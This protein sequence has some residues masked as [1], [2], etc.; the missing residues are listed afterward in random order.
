M[1]ATECS[2][3]RRPSDECLCW[4][5]PG[6]GKVERI[7]DL[8]PP[9]ASKKTKQ[10]GQWR[11]TAICGN[12]ITSSCLYVSALAA[13]YAGPLAP[14]ALLLV[15]G[16][17]YLF[18]GVSVVLAPISHGAVPHLEH[19]GGTVCWTRGCRFQRTV[20]GPHGCARG[21]RECRALCPLRAIVD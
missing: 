2:C 11:A 8:V 10:L 6:W 16:V 12:D 17:L 21:G 13:I 4:E 18:G 14:L 7:T 9:A 3:C 1:S 19:P 5:F 20:E 15:A